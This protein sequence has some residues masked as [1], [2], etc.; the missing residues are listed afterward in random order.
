V[1]Q[2]LAP[3]AGS[4]P[5]LLLLGAG[6]SREHKGPA[7][8][9]S[10]V[11]P[12]SCVAGRRRCV[13]PSGL[14]PAA[15]M[16]ASALASAGR[17]WPR[18]RRADALVLLGCGGRKLAWPSEQV[19]AVLEQLAAGRPVLQ[20]IHGGARG[21]DR[22]VGDAGVQL[23]WP[24]LAVPAQWQRDGR[25]A[26]MLRNGRMLEQAIAI[27]QAASTAEQLVKVGVIAFPGG[28]GTAGMVRL[29]REAA[30]AGWVGVAQVRG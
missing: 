24:V 7:V 4:G 23:G 19:A 13:P 26:G 2:G 21:A 29:A 16:A 14:L 28:A 3:S 27:A 10:S 11:S 25:G 30:A 12:R 20:L 5:F 6:D 8:G 1:P 17:L 22:A 18:G 9:P 15:S